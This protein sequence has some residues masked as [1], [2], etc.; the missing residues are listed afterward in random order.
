MAAGMI[1][2]VGFV[3]LQRA[4]ERS[5]GLPLIDLALLDDRVFLA[6]VCATFCFFLGNLSFYFVLTLYVQNGLGFS[7]F[8]AALTVLPLSFAFVA[9]S[10]VT[11]RLI[12]GCIVQGAGLAGTALL[13]A[14]VSQP[15]MAM[16]MLPLAVFGYGQGMVLAPLFSTVLTQVRHAHAGSG[17]GILTTTQQV[18]NG[19][20]VVLVGAVFFAVQGLDG[21]R[22]AFLSACAALGCTIVGSVWFL[23]MRPRTNV[24]KV[25]VI[26]SEA[27]Q[28]P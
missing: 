2:L 5:G 15:S 1:V 10:R 17:A 14:T 3:R 4:I 22:W 11:G 24:A 27:K 8:G 26:A 20:G 23:L 16:L 25:S 18:A 7:P 13:V 28:S 9:G 19:S 21:D 12:E 6:G